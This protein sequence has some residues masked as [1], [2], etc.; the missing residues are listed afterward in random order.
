MSR[1]LI[2]GVGGFLGSHL[3][4]FVR[5]E[6]Q[7]VTGTVHRNT[8]PPDFVADAITTLPCDVLNGREVEEA[9]EA[10]RPE[11]VFHFAAQ[12][13]PRLSWQDPQT[14]FRVNVLGTLYLLEAVRKT[15]LDPV[16]VIAGSSAEYGPATPANARLREESIIRPASPYGASKAAA[17]LLAAFYGEAYRLRVV[18][19]RPFLAI[20]PGKVGDVCSDF[21]R[22]IVAVERGLR[23]ALPVGNLEAVRDFLDV[24]DVVPACWLIARRGAPHQA[25]NICSGRGHSIQEVLDILLSYAARNIPVAHDPAL[26]RGNDQ[27]IVVGDNSRLRALGWQPTIPLERSLAEILNYWRKRGTTENGARATAGRYAGG[28]AAEVEG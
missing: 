21:A 14:T 5:Q 18:R 22:G 17:D 27:A 2:T 26:M 9:V 11:F 1:V 6:G 25:Y 20:G 13:L 12:S 19:I 10:A 4:E 23:S 7:A 24:R 3:A 16:I 28:R 8:P 15:G